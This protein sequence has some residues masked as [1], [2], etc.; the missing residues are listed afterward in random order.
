MGVVGERPK[1]WLEDHMPLKRLKTL[2][3]RGHTAHILF[4]DRYIPY[5]RRAKLLAFVTMAQRPVPLYNAAAL[6]ALVDRWRPETHTF[7]LPCGELTVTLEDVAMIL[8]LPIRGQAVTGDTASGNWRE[9]VEEY[10]GLEPP[11]APDGQ[12]QTKTSGV[13]LSWLRANFGQC[14]AE[15]D[16]AT[17]QRYCRAYVLYIFGSI[18]FPDSEVDWR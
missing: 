18:L 9:R 4:D 7:H 2:R 17:V 16:E 5:L 15:A 8:G 3:V 14:P 6:T 12:R 11:V 1:K 13:P 10:L